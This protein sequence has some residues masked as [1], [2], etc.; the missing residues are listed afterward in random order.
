MAELLLT[1]GTDDEIF[2]ILGLIV[3][4]LFAYLVYIGFFCDGCNRCCECKKK[5][6]KED[7]Q[8]SNPRNS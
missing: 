1:A 2:T 8:K 5:W 3:T 4:P 7:E 6:R